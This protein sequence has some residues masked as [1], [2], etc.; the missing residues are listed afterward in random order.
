MICDDADIEACAES[1]V[2]SKTFDNGL[3]C[4]AEHNLVV[5]RNLATSF[6]EA[7]ERQQCAVL[8]GDEG[9]RLYDCLKRPRQWVQW[10]GRSA[11]ELAE[12]AGIIR[13]FS[14]RLL[15][16]P[17]AAEDTHWRREKLLPL[18]SLLTVDSVAE[19]IEACRETLDFGGRGHTAI[20]YTESVEEIERFTDAL[21]VCR[22]LVRS[23]GTQ[24][25]CGFCTGLTPSLMLGC[26]IYGG[27]VCSDNVTVRHLQNLTRIAYLDQACP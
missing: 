11:A 5:H 8:S 16:L 9:A 13:P 3:V 25:T 4:G 12:S 26:G 2:L 21:P 20:I 10:S 15:V 7:L 19:G 17:I 24:G 18:L 14:I 23:P 22:I 1:V 6:T 27:S